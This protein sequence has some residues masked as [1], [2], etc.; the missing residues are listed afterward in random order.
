MSS[1]ELF[2][3]NSMGRAE[4]IRLI[5]ALVGVKYEDTRFKDKD[6]WVNNYKKRSPF[7]V[8]PFLEVN[9]KSIGG[10]REIARFLG[11]EFG[12]AGSNSIENAQISS[13]ADHLD[14]MLTHIGR[15]FEAKEEE[16]PELVKEF[17]EKAPKWL[18]VFEG[19]IKPSGWLHGDK[20]TWVDIH[21]Y[22]FLSLIQRTM[23]P[24]L[25]KNYPKLTALLMG[26]EGVENIAKWIKSRPETPH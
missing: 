26:V 6:D 20:L 11:E 21:V 25:L 12:I 19:M 14:D 2:Y 1:Y 5:F 3:F 7:G 24:D 17:L 18:A 15:I 10:G 23:I 9:G 8:A 22:H 16:R 4:Q 13:I